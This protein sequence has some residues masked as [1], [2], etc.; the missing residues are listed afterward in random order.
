MTLP[1]ADALALILVAI[2]A[3]GGL[4]LTLMRPFLA[5]EAEPV[6]TFDDAQ[7]E[8]LFRLLENEFGRFT[9]PKLSDDWLPDG[10]GDLARG[11]TVY[12]VQC[13][14]CHG[15][16]GGAET[17]T[18][19]LLKPPPRNFSLGVA[20]YKETPFGNPPHR[21]DLQKTVTEGIPA[22]SMSSFAGLEEADRH[23]AVDYV[24][25]L[26]I[27]GQVWNEAL[28]QLDRFSPEAAFFWARDTQKSRWADPFGEH[29]ARTEPTELPSG[30]VG[31]EK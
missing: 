14:N 28:A 21:D 3:V 12:E 30:Y 10:A 1:K 8:E 9:A 11:R 4:G 5:P 17:P 7:Q 29:P 6:F 22:T 20:A 13:L 24:M 18:A 15:G 2:A 16:E 26:M 27:R 23:A 31:E 25:Y 19:R